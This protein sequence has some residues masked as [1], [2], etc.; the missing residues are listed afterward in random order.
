MCGISEELV[1]L[2]LANNIY[3]LPC[4][5]SHQFV[6]GNYCIVIGQF[7]GIQFPLTLQTIESLMSLVPARVR[8]RRSVIQG[9]EFIVT[10]W[11]SL[12][13]W[14]AQG[15]NPDRSM[16]NISRHEDVGALPCRILHPA[17]TSRCQNS[18]STIICAISAEI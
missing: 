18:V 8:I 10:G 3:A 6:S 17:L 16:E 13:C 15:P 1:P 2:A 11:I 14:G 9:D 4:S 12:D 7:F 5:H